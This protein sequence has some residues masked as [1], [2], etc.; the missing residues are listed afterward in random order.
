MRRLVV[1]G[2]PR[3]DLSAD[4]TAY[5]QGGLQCMQARAHLPPPPHDP[6]SPLHYASR[7]VLK[8]AQS[9]NDAQHAS[10]LSFSPFLGPFLQFALQWL[11]HWSS[12][13]ANRTVESTPADFVERLTIRYHPCALSPHPLP[14]SN[15]GTPPGASSL[16]Q[17]C[18][19]ARNIKPGGARRARR[20]TRALP[21]PCPPP[22]LRP[23]LWTLYSPPTP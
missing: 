20:R 10:P 3:I 9:V 7:S 6:S 4:A 16:S 8:I 17:T 11:Q 23:P 21:S 15:Q 18:W 19:P 14:A 12:L 2:F 1:Y 5:L 13:S 22:R